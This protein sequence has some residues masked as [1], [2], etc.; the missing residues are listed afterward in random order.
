MD[1]VAAGNWGVADMMG[2]SSLSTS[3]S[4]GTGTGFEFQIA[5]SECASKLFL[6][7]AP[8]SLEREF[9]RRVSMALRFV[10]GFETAVAVASVGLVPV[11]LP[12]G[13]SVFG[14]RLFVVPAEIRL[15]NL[16]ELARTVPGAGIPAIL[17]GE[18]EE[19]VGLLP[20]AGLEGLKTP[21]V[22]PGSEGGGGGVVVE[23]LRRNSLGGGIG[24]RSSS[25]ATIVGE[26]A[27]PGFGVLAWLDRVEED[28]DRGDLLSDVSACCEVPAVGTDEP[29]VFEDSLVL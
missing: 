11:F 28:V 1:D 24:T 17:L 26:V 18:E 10:H 14:L 22:T 3:N 19:E 15:L 2:G 4:G 20:L 29:K 12:F 25:T 9:L 16:A 5:V 8:H 13:A 6:E 7:A 21:L 27:S 23:L